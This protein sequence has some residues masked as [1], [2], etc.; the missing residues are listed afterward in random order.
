MVTKKTANRHSSK[1]LTGV[2]SCSSRGSGFVSTPLGDV[3]IPPEA[4]RGAWHK[5][6]VTVELREKRRGPG[7]SLAGVVTAVKRRAYK[8]IV[9][10]LEKDKRL[11]L[12]RPANKRLNNLVQVSLNALGGAESGDVVVVEITRYASAREGAQ[13]KVAKVLGNVAEPGVDIDTIVYS[14]ELP[15]EFSAA[16][17]REAATVAAEKVD[18][19]VGFHDL[20]QLYTVTIDGLDAKDFDD[21]VSLQATEDGHFNLWVHIANVSHYVKVGSPI[22]KDA[23]ERGTSVYLPDRV[24]PMLPEE[25][26]NDLCSLKP[27]VDRLA[28]T[29]FMRVDAGGDVVEHEIFESVIRSDARLTYEEVDARLSDHNFTSETLAQLLLTLELLSQVLSKKR[30]SRGSLEFETV[31]PKIILN[32]EKWPVEVLIR[33]RTPATQII[34]EAMILTNETVASDM[35]SAGVPMIYRVHDKPDPEAVAAMSTLIRQLGYPILTLEDAHPRTFQALIEWAHQRP[36]KLLINSLLLR[37]MSK[38]KYAA[39]WQ[40]HFGLASEH[41]TH[42]TSPIRRY[43]DLI[44]HRLVKAKAAAAHGSPEKPSWVER[45]PELAEHC[46][47]REREA[48]GAERESVDAKMAQFMLGRVGEEFDAVISGVTSFGLFVELEN[49]AE[50]LVLA[51]K[52]KDDYYRFEAERYLMRGE[53]TGKVYR[54]GQSIRV[55]LVDVSVAKR[56]LDFEILESTK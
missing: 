44:V 12:V 36:E 49:S 14:H 40:E 37:A 56:E 5:D 42:F 31:E 52:L 23:L 30:I 24:I 15:V 39:K 20:R 53:R 11:A 41:Y 27:D 16:A 33:E 45:L 2:I 6:E 38:A 3:F 51:A 28:M 19:A 54:L 21:A 18:V 32:E 46:S 22:D 35:M 10:T 9:G 26:S 13:G 1:A 4:M 47:V 7:K 8:R 34:E 29:V 25:L 50:G 48:Q 55:R 17:L 43:P